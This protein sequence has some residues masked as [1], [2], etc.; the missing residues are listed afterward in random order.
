[1]SKK[2][3]VIRLPVLFFPAYNRVSPPHLLTVILTREVISK[4]KTLVQSYSTLLLTPHLLLHTYML[5]QNL[6]SVG[7]LS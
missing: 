5:S 3:K 7:G 6:V 4:K 2:L 1:M